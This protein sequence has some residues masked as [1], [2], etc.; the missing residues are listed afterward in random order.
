[1][2]WGEKSLLIVGLGVVMNKFWFW[3]LFVEFLAMVVGVCWEDVIIVLKFV[4]ELFMFMEK[5]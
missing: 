4:V 2:F 1:V 3:G 5:N